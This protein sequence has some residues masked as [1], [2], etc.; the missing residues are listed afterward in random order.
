M[1]QVISNKLRMLKYA[2][3][4]GALVLFVGGAVVMSLLINYLSH[5]K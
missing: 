5:C 3:V 2:L 4:V 1:S